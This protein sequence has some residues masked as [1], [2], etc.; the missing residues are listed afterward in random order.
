MGKKNIN[1]SF[2]DK[3]G[4]S[5]SFMGALPHAPLFMSDWGGTTS[6]GSIAGSVLFAEALVLCR[7]PY[8]LAQV[9]QRQAER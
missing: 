9:P 6:L 3:I 8:P 4:S 1:Y 2:E 5:I 7:F